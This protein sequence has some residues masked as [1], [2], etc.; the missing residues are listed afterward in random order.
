M[1]FIIT[2][3]N[4]SSSE[5]RST[6]DSITMENG[7]TVESPTFMEQV[8]SHMTYTV[9]SFINILVSYISANRFSW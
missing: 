5:N 9:A 6:F 7:V 2:M 1:R 3:E 4:Y 8:E